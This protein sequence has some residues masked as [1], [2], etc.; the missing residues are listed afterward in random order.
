MP[1]SVNRNHFFSYFLAVL[2]ICLFTQG[3]ITV[4]ATDSGLTVNEV[5]VYNSS[6]SQITKGALLEG[7]SYLEINATNTASSERQV[8]GIIG[9]YK[10]GVLSSVCLADATIPAQAA[11]SKINSEVFTI[12]TDTES[13]K[14]LVWDSAQ[15]MVPYYTDIKF[16]VNLA[17][18][19]NVEASSS[20]GTGW[21][22]EKAV[23]SSSTSY[24]RTSETDSQ[25]WFLIDL[26]SINAEFDTVEI[27]HFYYPARMPGYRIICSNDK[28]LPDNEWTVIY[29]TT[30]PSNSHT[31][32]YS[33]P[34][35]TARYVKFVV[36]GNV[37]QTG[38]PASC[39]TGFYTFG[40]YKEAG[41]ANLALGRTATSAVNDNA[42]YK[43]AYLVDNNL[44]TAWRTGTSGTS[45]NL[46]FTIDLQ[47][48]KDFSKVEFDFL[49]NGSDILF[50]S[51]VSYKVKYADTNLADWSTA[52][53]AYE[54]A[55]TP[56]SKHVVN[57]FSAVNGRFVRV[58][59]VKLSGKLIGV[60]EFKVKE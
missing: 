42:T 2:T 6:N 54:A 29:Q 4:Y 35:I 18:G 58:E 9:C 50:T 40:L 34:K 10:G 46:N 30:A 13:A 45:T 5:F 1:K 44:S 26:G 15:N 3:G 43:A 31:L 33:F 27:P 22:A 23:D 8:T 41:Y 20:N 16:N 57:S 38:N 36:T 37:I 55:T 39:T 17:F 28:E 25:P 56:T 48:S 51:I 47:N 7:N 14:I 60:A 12:P 24:W 53:V 32:L 19:K 59:F 11:N 52:N 21:P 49:D